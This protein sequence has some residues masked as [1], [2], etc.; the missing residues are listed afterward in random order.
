M[1]STLFMLSDFSSVSSFMSLILRL[2]T[3]ISGVPLANT[4]TLSPLVVTRGSCPKTS[5]AVPNFD[6]R[7]FSTLILIP[8]LVCLYSGWDVLMVTSFSFRASG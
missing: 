1:T 2:L 4:C 5:I 3:Y 8:P 6:K 7:E